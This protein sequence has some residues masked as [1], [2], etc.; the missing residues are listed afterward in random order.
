[1]L[2]L[3]LNMQ[4]I[5]NVLK[6]VGFRSP[7]EQSSTPVGTNMLQWVNLKSRCRYTII[8]SVVAVFSLNTPLISAGTGAT[9]VK[10]EMPAKYEK[11]MHVVMTGSAGPWD[12]SGGGSGV[13]VI[14]DGQL[15]QFD[16]GAKTLEHL[17]KVHISP[18]RIEYLFFTHL[19][20]DHIT[21]FT[22]YSYIYSPR[23]NVQIFGPVH[24]KAMVEATLGI[25]S[26]HR[27]DHDS[28]G[29]S[30]F[31]ELSIEEIAE[32]G[33]ILETSD[34]TVT[35]ASTVHHASN[36]LKSYAYRVDS[37]YGSVV[38]SG[39]T[40]PTPNVV[41]LAMDADILIHE[42]AYAES[43]VL[44]SSSINLGVTHDTQ[45]KLIRLENG[46]RNS[47]Q[48]MHWIQQHS[49]SLEVGKVAQT[50][51]VKKLIVY[52]Y[53]ARQGLPLDISTESTV[54]S[55]YIA[56]IRENYEGPLVMSEPLMVFEIG[57]SKR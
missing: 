32:A 36:V 26:V 30:P 35:A 7:D 57:G 15:L 4:K 33:V 52:H 54:K 43:S 14:V 41:E 38:I 34:F 13:A 24:T 50:A 28:L 47:P 55:E 3:F 56:S 27:K 17:E 44:M 23:T 51:K 53:V 48:D 20:I 39:D 10:A 5:L 21:D 2:D 46:L 37:K 40:A 29:L 12:R 25:Q 45:K 6:N 9:K 19:H 11:G 22:E 1:M 16:M 49:S 18:I 8:L 42:S 31:K